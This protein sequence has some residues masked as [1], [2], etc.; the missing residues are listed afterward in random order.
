MIAFKTHLDLTGTFKWIGKMTYN[1]IKWDLANTLDSAKFLASAVLNLAYNLV[2]GIHKTKWKDFSC[3]LHYKSVNDNL[4][5]YKC[6]FCHKNYSNMIDEELKVIFK[7][8]FTFLIVILINL[9][10]CWENLFILMNIWMSGKGLMKH[11][12]LK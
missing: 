11:H 5:K 4:I 6:L 9:I 3:F 8:T 7:N 12:F 1:V 2:E 10:H